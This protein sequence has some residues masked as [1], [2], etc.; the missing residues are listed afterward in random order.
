MEKLNEHIK[1]RLERLKDERKSWEPFWKK[2]SEMCSFSPEIWTEEKNRRHRQNV[3]DN[4][5][6]NALTYFSASFK[7]ILVPTTQRWHRLKPT[8]PDWENTDM[9]KAYL[10]Y[11]E[12]EFV[13]DSVYTG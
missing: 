9:V 12:A 5:A 6:R 3:F 4:T 8:N 11:D 2:L 1:Q 13:D 10:Q 7:S